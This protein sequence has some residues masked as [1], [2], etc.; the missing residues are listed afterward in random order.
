MKTVKQVSA[1]TGISVRT[2]HYYDEIGLLVPT[3]NTQSGYRL[4]D[5]HAIAR[6]QQILF[7]KELDFPLS[8]IRQIL[9]SPAFDSQKALEQ[10]KNLLIMKRDRLNNLISLV[11]DVMKG[12]NKMSFQEFDMKKIEAT[13]EAYAKEA[14]ERWGKTEAYAESE[15]KTKGYSK[16][17]WKRITE[18]AENIY[19]GFVDKMDAAPDS[20][21]VQELVQQWQNHITKNYYPCSK[22]ILAGLGEMYVSDPRFIQNIDQHKGGLAQFMH[23]A[24]Q[25]FCK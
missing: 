18:E 2:L 11:D 25:I 15:R 23:D 8:E 3:T 5:D 6:L 19:R 7:Y 4:Y 12:E 14:K 20:P 10:Q 21:E 24:I 9:D 13:R 1:L 16:E 22:E 17:D